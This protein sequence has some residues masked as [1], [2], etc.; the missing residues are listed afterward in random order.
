MARIARAPEPCMDTLSKPI[1]YICPPALTQ[2][3][4]RH[5]LEQQSPRFFDQHETQLAQHIVQGSLEEAYAMW[6]GCMRR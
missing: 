3:Q 5:A 4:W 6:S 2:G 1:P